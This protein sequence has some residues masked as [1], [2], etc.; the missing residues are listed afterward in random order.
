MPGGGNPLDAN[1]YSLHYPE[2]PVLYLYLARFG[3]H[4][5]RALVYRR[6]GRFYA[7]IFQEVLYDYS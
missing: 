3:R 1:H 2:V 6:I 7:G 5:S 4:L